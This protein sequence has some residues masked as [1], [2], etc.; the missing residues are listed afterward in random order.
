MNIKLRAE[1]E[2]R[3]QKIDQQ[4]ADLKVEKRYLKKV[5]RMIEKELKK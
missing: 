5:H 2:Q 3:I 1:T 4:I